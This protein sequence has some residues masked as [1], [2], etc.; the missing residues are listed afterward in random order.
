MQYRV[1]KKAHTVQS[2]KIKQKN[3]PNPVEAQEVN[4]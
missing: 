4:F 3:A 2:N 1:N